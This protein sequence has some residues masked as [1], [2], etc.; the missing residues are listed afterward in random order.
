MRSPEDLLGLPFSFTQLPP[1]TATGFIAEARQRGV[2]LEPDDLQAFHRLGLLVPM[3]RVQRDG[4]GIAAAARRGARG[5]RRVAHGA[6]DSRED[7]VYASQHGRLFD[8]TTERFVGRTRLTRTA[9]GITY[10]AS[11]YLY[12]RHQLLAVPSLRQLRPFLSYQQPDA[13]GA[14]CHPHAFWDL[15]IRSRLAM[16]A[17]LIVPLSALDPLQY[18]DI[19]GTFR[20]GQWELYDGWRVK[21]R[22]RSLVRWLG[23]RPVWL[24]EQGALLLGEADAIDPMGDWHRLVREASPRMWESLKGDA[25]SALDHRL[26]AEILLSHYDGLAAAGAAPAIPD[27]AGR[28]RTR[29]DTRLKPRGYVERVLT[30]FGLSPQPRLVLVVEGATELLLFPRLMAH[31]GIR[32]DREFIAI[33]DREGV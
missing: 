30:D 9:Y 7:L 29:F 28:E 20:S 10:Q 1:L 21:L 16:I 13:R 19:V 8:P 33:E 5:V 31:F 4:R 17:S 22:P 15:L 14:R 26:A 24:R 12:S 18:P 27:E 11:D 6:P 2:Q 3:L 23:V 32:V 25:R